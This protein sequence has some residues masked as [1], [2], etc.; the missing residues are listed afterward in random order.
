MAVLNTTSPTDRPAAP[1]EMPS[2]TVP[3]SSARMA[4]LFKCVALREVAKKRRSGIGRFGAGG[5]RRAGIVPARAGLGQ[6][7]FH[8][9]RDSPGHPASEQVGDPIAT[10]GA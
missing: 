7:E 9:S 1:T 3:S 4:D 10:G 6:H 5:V 8:R 2:K